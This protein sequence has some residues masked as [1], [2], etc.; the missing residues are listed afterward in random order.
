MLPKIKMEK[1]NKMVKMG[2]D[3]DFILKGT[4]EYE[5]KPLEEVPW[6]PDGIK[7]YLENQS[8]MS[9]TQVKEITNKFQSK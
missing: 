6:S 4:G 1:K 3:Y 2:M 9:K 5:T 7:H 8:Q